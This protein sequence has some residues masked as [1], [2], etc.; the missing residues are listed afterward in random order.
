M[1][2]IYQLSLEEEKLLLK[3]LDK[4]IEEGKIGPLSSSV[5]RPILFLP[6]P[7]GKGSRLCVD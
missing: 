5:G 3:Y 4:M 6:K 1:G 7:N 2:P